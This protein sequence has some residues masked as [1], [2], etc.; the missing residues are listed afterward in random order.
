MRAWS[1][2]LVAHRRLTE[3]LDAELRARTELS[4]DEFDLLHQLQQHGAPLRMSELAA[5]VLISRPTLSRAVDRLVAQGW[6]A[7]GGDPGDR[8]VVQVSLTSAGRA[9]WRRAARVHFDGVARRFEAPL[10][11]R[12]IDG[13]ADALEVLADQP[14]DAAV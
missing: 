14:P 3:A 6:V 5:R 13:L 11:T 1:A 12:Q 9:V 8:R 7:R 10:T 4:L 2:L